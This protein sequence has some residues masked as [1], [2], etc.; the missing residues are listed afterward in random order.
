MTGPGLG[1]STVGII[2]FGRIGQSVALKVK[3]FNAKNILYFNRSEKQ[4]E[5]KK[6]GA[7][8]VSFE[9]LLKQSDFIICCCALTKETQN[10]FNI[11]SFAKM[12]RTA[13]FIN[14]SR[15]G[16]VDQSAL[17]DALEN[18]IIRAA[19][20]D[21]TVPEPLPLDHSLFK[22]SNCTILPHIGSATIEARTAMAK[23][24]LDNLMNALED[25]PMPAELKL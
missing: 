2:G 11:E 18:G 1:E 20:L 8:K 15:G 19:G 12:K 17:V 24:T 9:E 13:V 4:I 3:A 16:L 21:V 10:M 7:I 23:L 6:T 5:A 25:K 14:T 22:M